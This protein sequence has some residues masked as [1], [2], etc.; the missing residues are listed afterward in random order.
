MAYKYTCGNKILT[1]QQ[2]QFYEEN[3]FVVFKNL[4]DHKLLDMCK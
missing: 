3:G 2:R 4:V 1:D